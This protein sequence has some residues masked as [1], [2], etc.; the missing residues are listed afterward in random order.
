MWICC[1]GS[2]L[3]LVLLQTGPVG[4][5]PLPSCLYPSSRS[6]GGE[7]KVRKGNE[8]LRPA[9]PPRQQTWRRADLRLGGLAAVQNR[10]HRLVP[11]RR[12]QGQTET[13]DVSGERR[14]A[15]AAA[16]FLSFFSPAVVTS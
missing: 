10:S 6:R 2:E 3:V 4:S 12:P 5:D 9:L 7:A 14:G 13:L 16:S 15:F 1:C 11:S 8:A